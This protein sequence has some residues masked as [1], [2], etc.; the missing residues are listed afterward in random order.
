[1]VAVWD[2]VGALGIPAL[3]IAGVSRATMGYLHTGLRL[4]IENGYHAL[5]I[6]EHRKAFTPTL[7]SVRKP[8]EPGAVYAEPRSI[9][10]VEQRWFVG[11]HANVGGG[12]VSD[13][14]AQVPLRWIMEKAIIH[15]LAFRSGVDIDGDVLSAQISDSYSEFLHGAYCRVS[16]R[17]HRRIGAEPEERADGT[18]FNV[19]ET[20]DGSVFDRWRFDSAYRPPNL[21]EWAQRKSVD[22]ATLKQAVRA[23]DPSIAAPNDA[24]IRI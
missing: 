6:D 22:L 13:L 10:S 19:N 3:S 17:C 5:A 9:G 4:G 1:M 7:W 20:I 18:H 2:T 15:G 21:S 16:P 12:C 14:L 23:D 24:D 11:A 8:K